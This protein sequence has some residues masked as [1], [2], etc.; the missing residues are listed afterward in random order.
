MNVFGITIDSYLGG[1]TGALHETAPWVALFYFTS[2]EGGLVFLAL[3][4]A[5][6]VGHRRDAFFMTVWFFVA[7]LPIF[8]LLQDIEARYLLP[9]IFPLLGL[10]GLAG[11]G[12]KHQMISWT[13]IKR[14][15]L[16]CVTF[17]ALLG[18]GLMAQGLMTHEVEIQAVRKVIDR[19]QDRYG[20]NSGFI[21]LTPNDVSDFRYLRVAY[22]E[23]SVYNV[24]QEPTWGES[25]RRANGQ[26]KLFGNHFIESLDELSELEG[27]FVYYGF[28]GSFPVTNLKALVEALPIPSK[29]ETWMLTQISQMAKRNQL[30]ESWIWGHP[31]I[32]F[33]GF[34]RIQHYHFSEI[35]LPPS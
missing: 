19:L 21:L 2:L 16:A 5:F 3:P 10:A 8:V 15:I 35:R 11:A 23:L 26:R 28:N 13:T 24:H 1:L 25:S 12:L 33:E 30:E 6:F 20:T 22:P 18:S 31:L 29:L 34:E 9:N 7:S 27:P 14:L 4:L 32:S 17:V